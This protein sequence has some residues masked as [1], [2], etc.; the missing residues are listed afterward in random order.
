[1][2]TQVLLP[3]EFERLMSTAAPRIAARVR[4]VVQETGLAME[5]QGKLNASGERPHPRTGNLRRSVGHVVG[6]EGGQL[7]VSLRAGGRLAGS[8]DV[9][10]AR[11]QEFG[12]VVTPVR[13]KWL[14]IP[15]P[16]VKTA[17]GV[18]R[19]KTPRDYPAR[20]IF[21]QFSPTQARL[22][23]IV[24]GEPVTRWHLRKRTVTPASRFLGR[25]FDAVAPTLAP[26]LTEAVGEALRP[27]VAGAP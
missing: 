17:A 24:G 1:M 8:A 3:S 21:Q 5:R 4:R 12:A 2:A 13:R 27:A 19:F 25:A 15:T 14:A 16:S 6:E 26:K 20:L 11:A 22:A 7:Q 23:E 9:I 10:Y 18:S